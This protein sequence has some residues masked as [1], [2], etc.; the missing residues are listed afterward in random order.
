MIEAEVKPSSFSSLNSC[1]PHENVVC[2]EDHTGRE[3]DTEKPNLWRTWQKI[4]K[5]KTY[6][7]ILDM[8]QATDLVLVLFSATSWI[9]FMTRSVISSLRASVVASVLRNSGGDFDAVKDFRGDFGVQIPPSSYRR[10]LCG[11]RYLNK[12]KWPN[13]KRHAGF[14]GR[15]LLGWVLLEGFGLLSPCSY[16]AAQRSPHSLKSLP[17][18]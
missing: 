14:S 18:E 1:S 15:R 9:N 6:Y 5:L 7:R 3:C 11:R 10:A 17:R 13:G 16:L 4:E 12:A 2:L 8:F